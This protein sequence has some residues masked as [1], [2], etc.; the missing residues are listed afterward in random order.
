MPTGW[1]GLVVEDRLAGLA[2]IHT[3]RYGE[4]GHDDRRLAGDGFHG[5]ARE[6]ELAH[7]VVFRRER[8]GVIVARAGHQCQVALGTAPEDGDPVRVEVELGRVKSYVANGSPDV[9]DD[10]RDRIARHAGVGD[11]DDR[12]AAVE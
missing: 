11:V 8:L 10:L 9:A 2:E 7:R 12:V 4:I 1:E 6:V 5:V 3:I